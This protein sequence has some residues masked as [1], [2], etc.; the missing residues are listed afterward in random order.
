MA[1]V[2]VYT[3]AITITALVT[4]ESNG[5]ISTYVPAS[6]AGTGAKVYEVHTYPPRA[7]YL[8]SLILSLILSLKE[9]FMS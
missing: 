3:L 2:V 9:Q 1:I 5:S 7:E 6:S 4:Y 8:W